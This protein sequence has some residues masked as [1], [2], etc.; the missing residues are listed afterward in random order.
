MRVKDSGSVAVPVVTAL[1]ERLVSHAGVGML[2]EVADLS[3][4]TAGL[5]GLFSSGGHCWRRHAPGVTLVRAAAPIADGMSNVSSVSLFCSSRG[6][7]FA[8][9]AARS[10]MRRAVFALG[11]ELMTP[12][13]DRVLAVA[14]TRAWQAAGYAPE[15]LT[16]DVDATLL[17]CHS[18]KQW[19][20][21]NY[22]SGFGFHSFWSSTTAARSR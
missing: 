9:P 20:A 1:G 8:R 13:L 18:D 5:N 21:P 10:T 22:K 11:G 7:I 19:A 17:G 4:L 14:R 2:A 6:A 15:S 3:G 12:G 16:I